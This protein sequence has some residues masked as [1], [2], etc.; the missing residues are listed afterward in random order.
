MHYFLWMAVPVTELQTADGSIAPPPPKSWT[1]QIQKIPVASWAQATNKTATLAHNLAIFWFICLL[2]FTSKAS[3]D[4][5]DKQT[6]APTLKNQI[7]LF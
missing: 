2:Y 4:F 3:C 1:L 6:K 7:L 5:K